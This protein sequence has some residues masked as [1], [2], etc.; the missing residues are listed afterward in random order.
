MKHPKESRQPKD[1][2]RGSRLFLHFIFW[3]AESALCQYG[4]FTLIGLRE[5]EFNIY[6][7]RQDE[8][9]DQSRAF[10]GCGLYFGFRE[11]CRRTAPLVLSSQESAYTSTAGCGSSSRPSALFLLLQP[12]G[13]CCREGD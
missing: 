7:E 12:R 10:P 2:A 8:E 6:N 1:Q 4:E 9:L 3:F 5:L 11:A 13:F